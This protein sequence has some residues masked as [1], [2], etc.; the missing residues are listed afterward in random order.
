MRGVSL[1]FAFPGER[2]CAAAAVK[3]APHCGHFR[4]RPMNSSLTVSDFPQP[5][6]E[7][8]TDMTAPHLE[9]LHPFELH[10]ILYRIYFVTQ[11]AATCPGSP[12]FCS[13]GGISSTHLRST[14]KG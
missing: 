3:V 9:F 11:H 13:S 7:I 14:R 4:R 10:G 8:A 2:A 12:C 1:S 5:V 6:H